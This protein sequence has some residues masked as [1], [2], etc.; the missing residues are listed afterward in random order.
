MNWILL[1]AALL[2]ACLSLLLQTGMFALAQALSRISAN[3]QSRGGASRQVCQTKPYYFANRGKNLLT[4]KGV[5]F[6]VIS[7]VAL[8]EF[9]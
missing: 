4:N 8:E 5:L 3:T 2:A 6:C 7:Y 9:V 1:I